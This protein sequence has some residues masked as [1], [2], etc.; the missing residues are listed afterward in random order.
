MTAKNPRKIQ[1]LDYSK[2]P[3]LH[4]SDAGP[5][6][7]AVGPSFVATHQPAAWTTPTPSV[8]KRISGTAE[9]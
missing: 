4:I 1:S 8:N 7:D 2:Y 9:R 5:N 6:S 3:N